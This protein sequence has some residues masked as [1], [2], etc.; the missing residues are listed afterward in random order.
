MDQGLMRVSGNFPARLKTFCPLAPG[1]T[2]NGRNFRHND[3]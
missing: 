2:L 3:E 1:M